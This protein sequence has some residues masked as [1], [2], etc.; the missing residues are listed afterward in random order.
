VAI[1]LKE[2]LSPE[3]HK[4]PALVDIYDRIEMPLIPVLQRMEA[5]GIKIDTGLL[6]E[7]SN[8]M[9]L[10]SHSSRRRSTPRLGQSSTSTRRSSL[11]DPL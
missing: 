3:L 11:A 1:A 9:A 5:R 8:N 6:R 2:M 7:S 10:S 4:D